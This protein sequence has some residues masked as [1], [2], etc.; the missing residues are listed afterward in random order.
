MALGRA[1]NLRLALVH[2]TQQGC[3]RV[4]TS[5]LRSIQVVA[6]SMGTG[7]VDEGMVPAES[8]MAQISA[9]HTDARQSTRG[10]RSP[11]TPVRE[12]AKVPKVCARTIRRFLVSKSHSSQLLHTFFGHHTACH[13]KQ[14]GLV[15]CAPKR[16]W[17]TLGSGI[18]ATCV[19]QVRVVMSSRACK[20]ASHPLA[21]RCP[22]DRRDVTDVISNL[23]FGQ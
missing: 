20:P 22:C 16:R 2:R 7:V 13:P 17:Y 15:T 23:P 5:S 21:P 10:K 6:N 19:I 18:I 9:K 4:L 8:I 3:I 11:A 14:R 1:C 12:T